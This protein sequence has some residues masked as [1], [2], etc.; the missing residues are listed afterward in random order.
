MFIRVHPWP[1]SHIAAD[2]VA[3]FAW[4]N[5]TIFRQ[6]A[7]PRR[8]KKTGNWTARSATIIIDV[9]SCIACGCAPR[10]LHFLASAN[11]TARDTGDRQPQ[12][13]I[14]KRIT[15]NLIVYFVLPRKRT[16]QKCTLTATVRRLCRRGILPRFIGGRRLL[17]IKGGVR[18]HLATTLRS[19]RMPLPRPATTQIVRIPPCYP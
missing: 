6:K 19:G 16:M 14:H 10:S 8:R 9:F 13:M 11:A 12:R 1:H 18:R 15:A 3:D 17:D 5:Q 4:R 7:V 2:E